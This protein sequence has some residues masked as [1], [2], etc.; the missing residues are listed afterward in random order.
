MKAFKE[1]NVSIFIGERF[2]TSVY[3]ANPGYIV[4]NK[5]TNPQKINSDLTH[6]YL[7]CHMLNQQL[8]AN[9]KLGELTIDISDHIFT[10]QLGV[11]CENSKDLI[12][13]INELF[14]N[15]K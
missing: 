2:T 5:L 8:D 10:K 4:F 11:I 6:I 1:K 12:K 14:V 9:L 15:E 13:E 3:D 7:N